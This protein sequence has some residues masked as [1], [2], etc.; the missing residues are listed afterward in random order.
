MAPT[1]RAASSHEERQEG[2]V[3]PSSGRRVVCLADVLELALE[4]AHGVLDTVR[5]QDVILRAADKVRELQTAGVRVEH[6]TD[7]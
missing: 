1:R 3:H 4:T 2:N 5:M 6:K 7:T